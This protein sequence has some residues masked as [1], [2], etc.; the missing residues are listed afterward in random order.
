MGFEE[1]EIVMALKATGNSQEAAV[2]VLLETF[3]TNNY[4][5]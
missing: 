5:I 3:R 2:S 4:K 1:E